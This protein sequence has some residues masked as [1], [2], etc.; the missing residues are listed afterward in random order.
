MAQKFSDLAIWQK[1]FSL[2][3]QVY[4]LM[5][6][7]PAEEKYALLSQLIR[8]ANGVIA[9][10]AEAHGR[11]YFADKVRILYI[12]RGELEETQS[13]LKVA[14][15]RKYI[16]QKDF[17]YLNSEYEGLNI[18]INKYINYLIKSINKLTD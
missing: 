2:L 1:G 5:S 11:Y 15:S 10:I 7:F 14:A 9:N 16:S 8:A 13:H 6:G 4:D 17:N 3:T 12:A 18:G